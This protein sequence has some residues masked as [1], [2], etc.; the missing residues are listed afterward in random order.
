M[1]KKNGRTGYQ[2]L[3]SKFIRFT[4][5][6]KNKGFLRQSHDKRNTL[7]PDQ[8]TINFVWPD[9]KCLTD[10][11]AKME[12]N[13][14]EPGLIVSN[15]KSVV[16]KR[17]APHN[18]YKICL[19]GKKLTIG[20][21]NKLGE[22]DLYGHETTPTLTERTIILHEEEQMVKNAQELLNKTEELGHTFLQN[23]YENK[24]NE[25]YKNNWPHTNTHPKTETNL[26]T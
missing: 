5:G 24:M 2:L 19:D 10:N 4:G 18:E 20:F 7:F 9:I 21:G 6:Y 26:W 25:C 23:L 14:S 13:C 22:V 16:G 15:I 17:G 1:S 12:I 11:R 8:S 3:D